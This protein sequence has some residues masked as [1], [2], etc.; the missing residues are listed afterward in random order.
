ME[1]FDL[2]EFYNDIFLNIKNTKETIQSLIPCLKGI[3]ESMDKAILEETVKHLQEA[4][5][6]LEIL[7]G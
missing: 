1:N 6:Q 5:K 3:S 2:N 7:K 4:E